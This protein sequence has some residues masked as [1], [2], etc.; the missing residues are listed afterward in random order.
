MRLQTRPLEGVADN[1]E[2]RGPEGVEAVEVQE[3]KED[4]VVG[5]Q[6]ALF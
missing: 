1:G 2:A 6:S 3:G 4:V 5:V